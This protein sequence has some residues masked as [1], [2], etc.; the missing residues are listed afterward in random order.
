MIEKKNG[1]WDSTY[2]VLY[3]FPVNQ[4]PIE[5]IVPVAQ[6]IEHR[7]PKPEMK[8]R[9]LSGTLIYMS[10]HS[11]I[12]HL[13]KK[14]KNGEYYKILTLRT[15]GNFLI[16]LSVFMVSKTF[17]EPIKAEIGYAIDKAKNRTY[18]FEME[19]NT[20]SVNGSV[21]I[22]K[23]D[24]SQRGL[25]AKVLSPETVVKMQPVDPNFSI[26]IPKIGA[27]ANII[28]NV[29]PDN[30]NVYLEALKKGVAHAAGTMFPGMN[31]HIFLF[32]HSTDYFWNV[33]TY[34]AL[35]YLLYKLEEGDEV[36]IV[37][38]GQ[39]IV[40]R[41]TGTRIVDPSEVEWLTRKTDTELLT[42]QTCWPPGTT[43]KRLLVFA[44]RVVN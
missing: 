44:E 36:N 16:L 34:N 17:F 9:F 1:W 39:R 23:P 21:P 24:L 15:V 4:R 40:Y 8:V 11:S 38:Q 3:H 28:E 29:D 37:F 7:F 14:R 31:G 5:L 26:V 33:G 32:A 6:R 2:E 41:V 12:H 18:V 20:A 30:E 19:A 35:F 25:L 10:S 22:T 13:I 43:L 42:L 27:N